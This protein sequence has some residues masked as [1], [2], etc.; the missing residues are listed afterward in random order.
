MRRPAVPVD[1]LP[2]V[3]VEL[4]VVPDGPGVKSSD[5]G[6][7]PDNK[8]S[9]F[10][11]RDVLLRPIDYSA[12]ESRALL[13]APRTSL[14][15]ALSSTVFI[16]LD[17]L[18]LHGH[19]TLVQS[20]LVWAVALPG[21]VSLYYLFCRLAARAQERFGLGRIYQPVLG[22][23][24]YALSLSATLT[25][26]GQVAG[27]PLAQA[28]PWWQIPY[29]YCVVAVFEVLFS[30]FALPD[31]LAQARQPRP[32]TGPARGIH[33]AGQCFDLD[34]VLYF[35]SQEHLVNVVTTQGELTVRARLGDLVSQTRPDDGIVA[36]R[37]HWV[38]RHAIQR[39]EK[40]T[41]NDALVLTNGARLPIARP[42]RDT[43]LSWLL[44]HRPDLENPF[45]AA[46]A[47]H[48]PAE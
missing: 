16:L 39:V 32:D 38:A 15:I 45:A 19:L 1:P 44:E 30:V 21:F 28:V 25:L 22:L 5:G 12:S 17:V 41:G 13:Q 4:S 47:A 2:W 37:S 29:S 20:I 43:V 10:H 23:M 9:T 26:F 33:C 46:Q 48:N 18:D 6:Y 11:A 14:F 31:I 27:M 42:R 3:F 36:H 34:Q 8:A 24:A 35:T 7:M 40:E